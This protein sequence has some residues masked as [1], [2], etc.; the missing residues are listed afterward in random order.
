MVLLLHKL[1]KSWSKQ[2]QKYSL[3]ELEALAP[4]I[5]WMRF[6][7]KV[8]HDADVNDREKTENDE[9]TVFDMEYLRKWHEV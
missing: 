2:L 8:L 6:V 5:P 1:L 9:V 3:K 4:G 7:N